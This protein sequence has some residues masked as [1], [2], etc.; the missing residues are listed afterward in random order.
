MK[1]CFASEKK[2][3]LPAV[4]G[5]KLNFTLSFAILMS[6]FIDVFRAGFEIRHAIPVPILTDS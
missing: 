1:L 6:N 3:V 4:I 5:E 2:V